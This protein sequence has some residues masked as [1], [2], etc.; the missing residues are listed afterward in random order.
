MFRT[1][2]NYDWRRAVATSHVI[3][4]SYH[5]SVASDCCESAATDPELPD[6]LQMSLDRKTVVSVGQ[7]A[8]ARD[9]ST[10]AP[11]RCHYLTHVRELIL[12]CLAVATRALVAPSCNAAVLAC[13]C[14]SQRRGS[15]EAHVSELWSGMHGMKRFGEERS[16][17]AQPTTKKLRS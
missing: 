15:Q 11:V 5:R 16:S 4:P 7:V 10:N 3:T 17:E 2:C 12:D 8:P 14:E 9:P 13:R 1:S 6:I